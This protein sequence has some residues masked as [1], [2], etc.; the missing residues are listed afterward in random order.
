MGMDDAFM[1]HEITVYGERGGVHVD[2][3]RFD[4]LKQYGVNDIPG[5]PRTR[6]RHLGAAL[7]QTRAHLAAIRRGGDFNASYDGEWRHFAESVRNGHAP[8][9][10]LVDGRAAMQIALAAD[11][12]RSLGQ[13]VTV[14]SVTSESSP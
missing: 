4:G 12:S 1:R 8:S 13:P 11:R 10:G 7:R 9:C 14:A 5:A 3:Y 2:C 6:L